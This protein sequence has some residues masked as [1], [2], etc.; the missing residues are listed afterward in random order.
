ME[1]FCGNCGAR[2]GKADRCPNCG[3][4]AAP[5]PA[6]A[7][8]KKRKKAKL[9]LLLIAVLLGALLIASALHCFG[10]VELPL[11]GKALGL[12]GI[13]PVD[14]PK[15]IPEQK[16]ER[17]AAE[18]YLSEF[19]TV[20]DR[21]IA[22]TAR[23]RT[24]AEALRDFAARGFQ[25]L[26]VTASYNA[27]GDYLG[28]RTVTADSAEKHPVYEARYLTPEN[29]LWTV[30]LVGDLFFAEPVSYNAAGYW[31]V[32]FV[33]SET[34]NIRS[35]DGDTN[36]F[37]TMTPRAD[38]LMI[39]RIARIDAETLNLLHAWEVGEP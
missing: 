19:G 25:D 24:E 1:R 18:N 38:A 23:L 28:S 2:L 3:W 6:P 39:H 12:V 8:K 33:L 9:I 11:L 14:G 35:Y 13:Y 7:P 29:T 27:D 37:Y 30:T 17:P 36:T 34:E 31:K 15:S 4:A 32:P 5:A 26:T 16:A 20:T 22:K 10:L 21:E